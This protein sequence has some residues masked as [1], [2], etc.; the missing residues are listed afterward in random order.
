MRL[1]KPKLEKDDSLV[2]ALRQRRTTRE[3]RDEKLPSQTLSNLLYAACGVNREQGPFDAPGVTAASASNS[4]EIDVYVALEDGAY[5]FDAE[6][7]ALVP[8]VS[9]DVRLLAFTPH[10]PLIS[11]GAPVQLIY[12]VDVDKL[13]HTR[14]FD[15][16]GLH[17][18]EVQKSY[19]FVDTGIIAGNVYLF[20]ASQG[21]GCWFHNC[22]RDGLAKA[23]RLGDRQRVLFAQTVGYTLR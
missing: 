5:R 22:D 13:E 3:I 18:P 11:P 6:E 19:Y 15:E 20:A 12:V 9:D 23:L 8:V 7:H 16:P 2:T 4:R 10:Q 1:E 21:L 14:G 17:D